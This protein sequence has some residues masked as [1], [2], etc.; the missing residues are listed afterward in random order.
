MAKTV[1][2]HEFELFQLVY[3]VNDFDQFV[4]QVV[5]INLLPGEVIVYVLSCNGETSEHYEEELSKDKII[6]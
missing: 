5:Q 6:V 2:K 4:R 1:L 3:L